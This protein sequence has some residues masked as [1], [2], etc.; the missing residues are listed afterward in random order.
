MDPISALSLA[1][2][3]IQFV[4]F[5][6]K[7]ISH[8]RQ[9]YKSIDGALSDKVLVEFLALDLDSLTTNLHKSLRENQPVDAKGY[10]EE[11]SDDDLALDDLCR[12]CHFIVK[13]L[14]SRLD[15]LKVQG[16]SSHRN[17]ESF[18][19]ALRAS[20][21]REEMD[22]LAAQL[23][24]VRSEIEFRV[25]MSFRGSLKTI[26]I[27]QVQTSHQLSQCTQA[28]ITTFL[29]VRDE[30]ANE[31][32]R[33]AEKLAELQGYKERPG[34]ERHGTL[35]TLRHQDEE[36]EEEAQ[37]HEPSAAEALIEHEMILLMIENGILGTL[38]F[39]SSRDRHEDVEIA[40]HQT[41]EW[42]Y[43][44]CKIGDKSWGNFVEWLQRDDGFYWVNG[45]AGSGKSTLMKYIFG[46]Q[47]TRQEL[48][49][50]AGSSS[51]DMTG[52]F[53]WNSGMEEQRSQRGLLRTLLF[54][55]LQTHRDLI[56]KVL[57]HAWDVW[58]TQVK[59]ALKL[60]TAPAKASL[61]SHESKPWT[62]SQLKRAFRTLIQECQSRHI[63]LCF[64]I[65]GLDEYDGDHDDIVEYF[66]DFAHEPGVKMC[67]SSRPLLV[68]EEAFSN[69][70]GL[71]L[72]NLTH[73]DINSYV[74]DKLGN[75]RHMARLSL[76]NP[77]QAKRLVTEIVTKADG[78]FLWVKLVVKSLLQG[79]RDQNRITDLQRRLRHLPADLEALYEHML[80]KTD[81]FYL[82]QASQIFQIVLVAQKESTSRQITLLQLSW[83]EDE[84]ESLAINSSLRPL[85]TNEISG[86]CKLMDSRLKSVCSGLLESYESKYS[87]I[88]PDARV[89]FLHRTVSDF[90]KKPS[91]WD[92]IVKHTQ[93]TNFCPQLSLLRSNVL[94]LKA[95]D[96]R[97]GNPLDMTIIRDALRFAKKAEDNL[98][99]GFPELL[100]QLD[101]AATYQW[102]VCHGNTIGGRVDKTSEQSKLKDRSVLPKLQKSISYTRTESENDSDEYYD[103]ASDD[104]FRI[105]ESRS[106]VA[107]PR[108]EALQFSG[109]HAQKFKHQFS[110]SSTFTNQGFQSTV[111]IDHDSTRGGALNHWIHGIE[112]EGIK[113]YNQLIPFYDLAKAI[114]LRHYIAIKDESGLVVDH[115]V[116]HHLLI[117]TVTCYSRNKEGQSKV[118]DPATVKRALEAGADPNFSFHGNSPWEE[119]LA[120]ALSHLS[121]L[122]FDEEL[123]D[124]NGMRYQRWIKDAATW[125]DIMEIFLKHGASP[126]ASSKQHWGQPR[127][128]PTAIV[129]NFPPELAGRRVKL[130]AVI[131][132]LLVKSMPKGI[133]FLKQ[134]E[135]NGEAE[136]ERSR[137]Q[138]G[139]RHN[140]SQLSGG[141]RWISSWFTVSKGV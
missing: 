132:T 100:D 116:N 34:M 60:G 138:E 33:Q 1:S 71:K 54:E 61:L 123:W 124:T 110:S 29:S 47:R 107:M 83:A 58:S 25:L 27:Q 2:N 16:S 84:D 87:N 108:S 73:S 121:Q 91:V 117:H 97:Y 69:F 137:L 128:K 90:F 77:G 43:R 131:D 79:L 101:S 45:K 11:Y 82:E 57:P 32:Q 28:I 30:F 59:S 67:L 140:V 68:F 13:K 130:A 99:V 18:K 53:F 125:A 129:L 92:K 80:I 31:L 70:P 119:A 66:L 6:C 93:G 22:S 51:F 127:R 136:A 111:L 78:V 12:R 139:K 64:F 39:P 96:T 141:Y 65:D 118:P 98:E 120:G 26:A 56:P 24:D 5:G 126:T 38:D 3:V 81:P 55:T 102:R 41:F 103:C 75:H 21:S 52:F 94:Q 17:W 122:E 135:K 113:P 105:K 10:T 88:A 42:I 76:K 48:Q 36:E 112:L 62:L 63:K 50:W 37:K 106:A 95:L 49:R 133:E 134:E 20:W 104:D 9:L 115:D 8:S 40:H 89:V 72:Q 7:L 46:H 74:E 23:N 86:R 109:G 19:K 44:D 14:I 114:G 4:D 35:Q 85:P 15:R